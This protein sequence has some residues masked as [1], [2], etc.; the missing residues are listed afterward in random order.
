MVGVMDG[1]IEIVGV[2]V[3]VIEIVGVIVG[4]MDGVT[5]IVGVGV[6]AILEITK[7][8]N[9]ALI[10]ASNIVDQFVMGNRSELPNIFSPTALF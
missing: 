7:L 8:L 5:D 3:G 6:G 10:G 1:V 4:V 9:P 2:I